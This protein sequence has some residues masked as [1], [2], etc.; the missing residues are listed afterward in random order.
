MAKASTS[1][2]L[3]SSAAQWLLSIHATTAVAE[4]NWSIW[5]QLYQSQRNQLGI[6][7]A[8]KMVFVK[9]NIDDVDAGVL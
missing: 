8:E 2:P 4:R 6:E 7:K 5:G 3:L 1:F 9:A